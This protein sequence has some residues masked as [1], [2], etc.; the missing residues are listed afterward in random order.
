[1]N[2]NTTLGDPQSVNQRPWWKVRPTL[3]SALLAVCAG[4]GALWLEPDLRAVLWETL[5]RPAVEMAAVVLR[6]DAA[7][8]LAFSTVAG[9]MIARTVRRTRAAEVPAQSAQLA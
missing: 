2:T 6:S 5:V 3:S 7:L 8:A 1:M 9:L 4:F